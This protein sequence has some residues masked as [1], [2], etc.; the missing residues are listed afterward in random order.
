M[1]RIIFNAPGEKLYE[2]GVKDGVLYPSN[3][4]GGYS[5]GVPWNGL[6]NVNETPEG[7]EENAGYGDDDKYVSLWSKET[8]GG[9]IE[10]YQSPAEFDACD[11]SLEI[12]DGV[13]IGQQPRKSFGFCYKTTLGNDIQDLEYGYILHLVYN[14]KA[15][16]S[17]RTYETINDSPEAMNLSWEFKT[18]AIPV[19]GYKSTSI[20]KINSTKVEPEKM[21]LI[22][23]A[24]YGTDGAGEGQGTDPSLLTPAAIIALLQ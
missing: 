3:D 5:K 13:T 14:A 18:T 23:D 8:F 21:K 20:L 15:Q 19:E 2:V 11:G 4:L 16:P 24:L 6:I 17:E 22:E 10:A 7:G 9:T 12:L 1:S